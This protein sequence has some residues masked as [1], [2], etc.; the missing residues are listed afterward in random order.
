M[1]TK[2]P[3]WRMAPGAIAAFKGGRLETGNPE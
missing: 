2:E 3:W 1:M